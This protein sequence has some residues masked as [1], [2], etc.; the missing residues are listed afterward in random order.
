M[1]SKF[2]WLS[3]SA[4]SLTSNPDGKH[5]HWTTDINE[6]LPICMLPYKQGQE[7][8]VTF[9]ELFQKTVIECPHKP[10]L[11]VK[12]GDK[13]KTWT[14]QEYYSDALLFATS[15]ISLGISQRKVVNIIGF[16][17]PEWIL[18]YAGSALANCIPTGIYTTSGTETC[19]YIADHSEAE[20]IVAQNESHLMKYLKVIDKLPKIK[21]F[22]VYW[23]T[24]NLKEISSPVPIY[25]WTEFLDLGVNVDPGEVENRMNSIRPSSCATIVYTSGTTGPPKG[26][27]LSHDNLAWSGRRLKDISEPF[28]DDEHAV[29]YL[30]LSHVVQQ[31]IDFFGCLQGKVCI[32][33]ADEDALQGSLGKTIKEVRPTFF[34]G[35][36]RVYEKFEE[37]IKA[38]FNSLPPSKKKIVDWAREVAYRNVLNQLENRPVEKSFYVAKAVFLDK[39]R[40]MLGFDRCRTLMYGAAPLS[41]STLKFFISLNMPIIAG[42]GMSESAAPMTFGSYKNGNI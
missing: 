27:L 30:P 22:V 14:F 28:G 29:S 21:A 31:T 25:N 42:Y 13:W 34:F 1:E 3:E 16:N 5:L 26:V 38:M 32:D 7:A 15:L 17:S 41:R 39:F 2:F 6:E 37:K 24:G 19:H 4:Q 10:A 35:V 36:P 18:S 40:E 9:V 20:L 11:R 33:F 12:K 23:P 8:P